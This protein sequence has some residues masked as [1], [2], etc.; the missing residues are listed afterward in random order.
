MKKKK[1]LFTAFN[2]GVGG[3]SSALINLLNQFDYEKYDVT[4][5]LQ[6]RQGDFLDKLNPNVNLEDYGLS[7]I[8]NKI[9][10]RIAN[11]F[12]FIKILIKNFHKYDFAACYSPGYFY[13]ALVARIASKNNAA[14][15]HT[16]IINYM[17]NSNIMDKKDKGY[18]T[19][20]KVK[21]FLNHMFFRKFKKNIFV[22]EDGRKAYLS[23]FPND[24]DK[25]IVCHNLIDYNDILE[26]SKETIDIHVP[27]N[28]TIFLNVS[29]HTEYD[30][31]ITRIINACDKLNSEYDFL[32][33]LVGDGEEHERY[34]N[35]VK[36]KHLENK[37][38]FLGLKTNPFPYY[39]IADAFV[40]S[41]KF[42]GFPVVFL[43]SMIMNLPLITTDVSDANIIIKDKFG[44]VVSNDDDGIYKGMK[45]FLDNGF[46]IK[47]PFDYKKFNEESIEI[48][49]GL[50]DNE[51]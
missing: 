33:L 37:V 49:E 5:L 46:K 14:W 19:E 50:I 26:K 25:T 9:L 34:I 18:S 36:E 2:L 38:K 27:R 39:K 44:Y 6:I 40:L 51:N 13:S 3:V 28:K 29:R 30:K 16:N 15:M 11:L 7:K 10:K 20:K 32:L 41:S 45:Q 47:K 31:R 22:S 24:E 12:I 1:V 43:E 42:E 8:K 48:L 21:K 35:I 23:M 4:L 17:A